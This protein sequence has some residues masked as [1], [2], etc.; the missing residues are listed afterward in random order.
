MFLPVEKKSP[1]NSYQAALS[2]NVNFTAFQQ[3]SINTSLLNRYLS[4]KNI[5][6][7]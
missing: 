2:Q 7:T 6:L 3:A 1:K 5:A 4:K